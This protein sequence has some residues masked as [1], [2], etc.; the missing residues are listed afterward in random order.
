MQRVF[1]SLLFIFVVFYTSISFSQDAA[2]VNIPKN[3][4]GLEVI[5][6]VELYHKTVDIDSSKML[7]DL[8][9]FIPGIILDMRYATINNFT[10][11]K[12]YKSSKAFLRIQAAKALLNVEKELNE[13]GY[14]L[15]VFDAYRPYDATLKFYKIVEDKRFVATPWDGSRHNRAC[16]VDL[17][18]INISTG[19]ELKM[20][21]TFDDFSE[22]A[23][24]DYPDL[25]EEVLKNRKLLID[26]MRK[27]GFNVIDSEWWHYD[28]QG[29]D[30]YELLNI[31][32]EDL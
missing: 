27:H 21:T 8:N 23:A 24:A 17:T 10:G 31:D 32:H 12:V 15:M 25:P 29:W 30:K 13:M 18:L 4:Y 7:V 2:T 11:E 16:A 19:E 20:P 6:S 9:N 5:E 1:N 26:V 3:E 22:K 28:Y 14:G